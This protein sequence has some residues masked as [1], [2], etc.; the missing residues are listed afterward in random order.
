MNGI[1]CII[2]ITNY[3]FNNW[4]STFFPIVKKFMPYSEI[5]IRLSDKEFIDFDI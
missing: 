2:G 1:K 4:N 5:N 3:A